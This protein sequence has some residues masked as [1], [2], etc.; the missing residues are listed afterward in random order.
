MHTDIQLLALVCGHFWGDFV[1]QSDQLVAL[2]ATHRRWMFVHVL[3]VAL[4]TG[5][6]LGNVAVAAMLVP[7]LFLLHWL[8][9]SLKIRITA[10]LRPPAPPALPSAVSSGKDDCLADTRQDAAH[11]S[12]WWFFGDQLLHL[13]SLL[14]LWSCCSAIPGPL[15][16]HN[17]W[18]ALWGG[19][20]TKGL[21]LMTGLALGIAGVGIVL[22]Y[23]MAEFA[24]A[25]S[26]Q[27]RQGL[28]RGGK[29]IGLLERLLVFMFVLA[30][31][32][33]AIGFVI[34][35]KSVFRIGDLT[36]R[37]D[38][39]HAEYIMIGTLRSFAYALVIAFLTKWLMNQV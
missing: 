24:V 6:L 39:D 29:T 2:K 30:G 33:E 21:I 7:L 35:A 15:W 27:S 3:Q 17:H 8:I 36:H 9:D 32:P 22:K 19:Q 31:K 28:P 34:A 37:A 18:L 11:R 1:L 38:R 12:L 5:L 4:L 23:Q 16:Q 20:Y 10:G 13:L 25:L 26:D 14:V